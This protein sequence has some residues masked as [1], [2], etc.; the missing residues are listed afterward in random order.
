MEPWLQPLFDAEGMRAVDRWAIEERGSLR[1]ELMEAAGAALAEAVAELAARRGRSG[2]SAAR[3]TTA[4]T[5]WSPPA[6]A[7]EVEDGL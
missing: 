4:A 3:G 6:Q 1:P 5:G 7:A 2:S